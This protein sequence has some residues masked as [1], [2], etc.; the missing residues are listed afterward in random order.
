MTSLGRV[1]ERCRAVLVLRVDIGPQIAEK[2]RREGA[3]AGRSRRKRRTVARQLCVDARARRY[4]QLQNPLPVAFHSRFRQR[5]ITPRVTHVGRRPAR[6]TVLGYVLEEAHH[7]A[8]LFGHPL[9]LGCIL[10]QLL[11]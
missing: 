5:A 7:G 1:V 10:W 4:Q 11:E 3:T 2:T 9:P 8:H 6:G